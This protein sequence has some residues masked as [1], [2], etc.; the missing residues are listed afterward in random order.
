MLVINGFGT[1]IILSEIIIYYRRI[2][3][4][5]FQFGEGIRIWLIHQTK[6]L[7]EESQI[8]FIRLRQANKTNMILLMIVYLSCMVTINSFGMVINFLV[9]IIFLRF[10]NNLLSN[11][12]NKFLFSLAF[13]DFQVGL[14]GVIGAILNCLYVK[15]LVDGDI[16]YL[17]GVLPLF[18]SFFM[19]ILSLSTLTADRLIAVIYALRYNSIMTELRAN[20]LVCF[21]WL[22]VAI[23][24][25]IQGAVR[26]G[27]SYLSQ[28]LAIRTY[29]LTTIFV[30]GTIALSYGNLRLHFIIRNKQRNFLWLDVRRIPNRRVKP[31]V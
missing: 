5:F 28:E 18:G 20:L 3:T 10:H 22:T 1:V 6:Q 31:T 7:N 26:S 19:S 23:I 13:A 9:I 16:V 14:F 29:Q 12:N 8:Y 21:T 30:I 17:C 15:G 27:I 11:N 2:R 24:L 25:V 4:S